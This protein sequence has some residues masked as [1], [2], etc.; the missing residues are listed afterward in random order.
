MAITIINRVKH[1]QYYPIFLDDKHVDR[2]CPKT[3]L[4]LRLEKS[5]CQLVFKNSRV[6]AIDVYDG[7]VLILTDCKPLRYYKGWP[8][9]LGLFL[10]LYLYRAY[11]APLLDNHFLL[12]TL[13]PLVLIS[14]IRLPYFLFTHFQIER[15]SDHGYYPYQSHNIR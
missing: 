3:E 7:D 14:L 13:V 1:S 6:P 9:W 5:P 2:L 15:K 4:E 8:T 11:M 10:T 12:K